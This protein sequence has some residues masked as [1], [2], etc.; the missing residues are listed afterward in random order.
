MNSLLQPRSHTWR[1][2]AIFI[3]SVGATVVTAAPATAAVPQDD[4][5]SHVFN[6]QQEHGFDGVM[7]PGMHEGRSSWDPD[8][9]C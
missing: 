4:Y 2:I 7:N 3:G 1:R 8:H 6:C 9:S 5:A